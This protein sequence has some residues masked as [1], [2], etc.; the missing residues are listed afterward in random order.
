LAFS[1]IVATWLFG[2]VDGV[3]IGK[4]L[5]PPTDMSTVVPIG[6][7]NDTGGSR[8]APSER[9]SDTGDASGGADADPAILQGFDQLE[10]EIS[11]AEHLST[12]QRNSLRSKIDQAEAAYRR[13]QPCVAINGLNAFLRETSALRKGERAT[14]AEQLHGQGS[15]LRSNILD[16]L[17]PD[18]KCADQSRHDAP[19][20]V[21]LT[22]SDVKEASGSITFGAPRTWS[23]QRLGQTYTQVQIP[24]IAPGDGSPG[25]PAVPVLHRLVA[26]PEDAQVSV[27]AVTQPGQTLSVNLMPAQEG[28]ADQVEGDDTHADPPFAK[29]EKLYASNASYPS[30][31]CEV[32]IVG[33]YRD[34]R[35][36]QLSCAAAQY[37][38]VSDALTFFESV[39][40]QVRFT[41]GR[42][43]F[44]TEQMLNPFEPPPE[45]WSGALLNGVTIF[46]W[47][48]TNEP[49]FECSGSEL[50]ILTAPALR[51]Q[52][53]ELAAWKRAKGISTEVEVVG[54]GAGPGP[55]TAADIDTLIETSY[56]RCLVRPSYVLLMGD[57]ELIPPST[58]VATQ[59]STN[60]GSDYNYANRD[61]GCAVP[62]CDLLPDF[63]VGRIPV[64]TP[65]Q[66]TVVVDKIIRYEQFPPFDTDFYSDATI[67]SYH[68]CCRMN[69]T[70]PPGGP[71]NGQAGTDQRAFVET[72]ETVQAQL[73]SEGYAVERIYNTDTARR[74]RSSGQPAPGQTYTGDT[75]PRTYFNGALL[76][77]ALR[78]LDAGGPGFQWTGGTQ[79]VVDAFND[80]RFLILHRDHGAASGWGDPN[81]RTTDVQDSL[82]NGVL[83]PVVFSVNC[84]SGY[85]DNETHTGNDGPGNTQYP[86]VANQ[87]FFAEALLREDNGGAVG[88]IGDTRD[89]QTWA[90][91]TMTIGLVDAVWPTM[92]PAFGAPSSLTRLGDILNQAKRYTLTKFGLVGTTAPY[93]LQIAQDE[94]FLYHV[95]GD[96]T[97][98]MWTAPPRRLPLEY[99]LLV[100]PE[101]LEVRYAVERST[102]T[103]FQEVEGANRNIGRAPVINGEAFLSYVEKPVEGVPIQLSASLLNAVSQQLTE[104][105]SGEPHEIESESEFSG[106]TPIT[107]DPSE[108][109]TVGEEVSKQYASRGVQFV[110]DENV[111][112]RIIDSSNRDGAPT[113]SEPHSLFNSGDTVEPGSAGYP[114]TITFDTPQSAVGMFL[115]NGDGETTAA[116]LTAYD[117]QGAEVF[118]VSK[119]A[120]ADA[121][122]T[123]IGLDAG[124]AVIREVRVDYGDTLR[125]E[126][127]DHL[128]FR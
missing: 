85:F 13:G 37:N 22:T 93:T 62:P 55:D 42:E 51:E 28:A 30:D 81:F 25:A 107:F 60:T 65:A 98:E 24:G 26:V 41:G 73:A 46:D 36:A 21:T 48:G 87:T 88:V 50:L 38:P 17:S 91:N 16:S 97:L 10:A 19:P 83:T 89:S 114:M 53:D 14:V 126:D 92:D 115:G 111:T 105:Q 125:G 112:P 69:P 31:V 18:A 4:N 75:T 54:D 64:D 104:E 110:D 82:T 9:T 43:T 128:L 103:A 119:S 39:D 61:D 6:Q 59:F 84:G 35:V 127:I 121:V 63:A 80:G 118:S 66:A 95:L 56:I 70:V 58:Y 94:L 47:V 68:Q 33:T 23:E 74:D 11:A 2:I 102:I 15:V 20:N 76:P 67:A 86:A 29:N 113:R 1:L 116:T 123:F 71:L 7:L 52:A 99:E 90:N 77:T 5:G 12:G 109:R 32:G 122:T 8:A 78:S 79:D 49:L 101:L 3:G 57:A 120:F 27:D 40:F 100:R 96:P 45:Q 106:V 44:I 108:G 124:D 72:S 34:L 117:A